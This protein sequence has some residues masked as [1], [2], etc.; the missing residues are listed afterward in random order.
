MPLSEITLPDGSTR[1]LGNVS[2]AHD[3]ARCSAPPFGSTDATPLVP[4][5]KW[6]ALLAE[7]APG[8]D[9]AFLPPVH[10]QNGVGSC[11][12][13][14]TT[15]LV[16]SCRMQQGLPYVKL[17]AADLYDRI[18]GGQDQGSMLE[19]AMAEVTKAGVGTAATSGDL[20]KRG[21]WKGPAPAAERMRF[22]V[23]ELFLCPTF[24]H[25]MS[26]VLS[27]FRLNTG[28]NWANNYTPDRDGWLPRPQ[29]NAGG[30]AIFGYKPAKR[31]GS[32][33][34]YHQ[35]SWGEGWGDKGRFVIPESA[36]AG[37]VGGWFAVRSV[38][39]EGGIVPAEAA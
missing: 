35:N 20:W 25:C 11:N 10:D 33:G 34:I 9:F 32:Y 16:E 24:D 13:E 26:A 2:R 6:D 12:C 29:G 7:L 3:P 1:R 15:A 31:G 23:L 21:H 37:P 14:A 17:S 39:D 18:N 30:H 5:D 22:R 4:R 28:I 19:D 38:V 27:G 36:Y 8:P